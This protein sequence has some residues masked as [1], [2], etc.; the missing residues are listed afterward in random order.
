MGVAWWGSQRWSR[1]GR[2]SNGNYSE[3]LL[4]VLEA[5]SRMSRLSEGTL[6]HE[7][8][9]KEEMTC[10][11]EATWQQLVAAKVCVCLAVF[12]SRQ[13]CSEG[14]SCLS[15]QSRHGMWA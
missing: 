5:D 7:G 9:C 12:L 2:S 4:A 11:A 6:C 3:D 10:V 13:D 1:M 15:Y 8:E 14:H